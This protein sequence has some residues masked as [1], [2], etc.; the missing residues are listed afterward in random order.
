MAKR[1]REQLEKRVE[2]MEGELMKLRQ[3]FKDISARGKAFVKQ[4]KEKRDEGL[5]AAVRKQLGL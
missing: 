4:G 2:E 3:D 5:L 1:T